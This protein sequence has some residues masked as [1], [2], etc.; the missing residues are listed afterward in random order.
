M[1]NTAVNTLNLLAIDIG[2][3]RIKWGL[4]EA[5]GVMLE[6]GDCLHSALSNLALPIADRALIANVAGDA[7]KSALEVHLSAYSHV[8]YLKSTAQI[9]GVL[10]GYS[11]PETLGCDRWAALI[12]AWQIQQVPCLVV[13]AGTAATIDALTL[14]NG[15][16]KFMGGLILPGLDLMQQSLGLATA[17]LPK[18]TAENAGVSTGQNAFATNT[19]DAIHTGALQAISGAITLMFY[20]LHA[21]CKQLPHIL[22]SGG[23]AQAIKDSLINDLT[24]Q[25]IVVD[26]LV[27]RG[28]YFIDKSMQS[29]S[30]I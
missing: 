9:A 23:N 22:I 10:N 19:V 11:Q 3:T 28:L 4:F 6:H 30:A 26:H 21:E 1:T 2:N 16:G 24:K 29:E 15:Q 7:V 5:N 17:L 12:A 18:I 14:N 13:N 8:H 25:A 27:L 20:Q